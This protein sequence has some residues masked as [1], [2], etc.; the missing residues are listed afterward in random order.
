MSS[1]N[2][3]EADPECAQFAQLLMKQGQQN[4]L[5]FTNR[6]VRKIQATYPGKRIWKAL[7]DKC[8]V[9]KGGKR[10]FDVSSFCREITKP[11]FMATRQ[12]FIDA[13]AQYPGCDPREVCFGDIW[14][15][16]KRMEATWTEISLLASD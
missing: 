5:G 4:Q 12:C 13:K 11:E 9:I 14:R 7:N 3:L 16:C 10:R 2:P 8:F 15:L 1:G 6:Q